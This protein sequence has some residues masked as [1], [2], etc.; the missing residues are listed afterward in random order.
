MLL[1]SV[2]FLAAYSVGIVRYRLML[3]DQVL[4][5]GVLYY[6]VSA[7]VTLVFSL[8][9]AAVA[10]MT[11]RQDLAITGQPILVF[12]ILTLSVV[13]LVWFRDRVQRGIDR[14]FFREKYRL[15]RTLRRV[16]QA[17]SGMLDRRSLADRMLAS[18]A[19]VLST[20]QG[21]IYLR[22]GQTRHFQ[23]ISSFGNGR[24]PGSFEADREFFESLR[25]GVSLQRIRSGS[26]QVQLGMRALE[27]ELVYGLDVDGT[28]AGMIAL[29]AKPNGAAYN[30]EDAAFLAAIGRL[31]GV[32]LHFGRVHE[33]LNRMNTEFVRLNEELG[34]TREQRKRIEDRL[35][36][37]DVNLREA[38]KRIDSYE[39]QLT[40][41]RKETPPQSVSEFESELILGRSPAILSVMETARKVSPTNSSV[42]IR[43]ESGTGKELLARAIHQNSNR[44]A[45][46]MIV[47]HC[48]AL[49][50]GVLESELFGHVKGAFTDAREDK[51]GRFLSANGGTLF[52]DEIGDVPLETQVKLLRALQERMIEPVGSSKSIP[53]DVRVVAATHRNLEQFI[54]EGRFREDLYYRL[55]V[56]SITLPPLREREEDVI[57]LSVQFLRRAAQKAGKVV[58]HFESDVLEWLQE[59]HWPGNVREL[60]N[61]IERAVVLADSEG[62]RLDDLPPALLEPAG[63]A[64]RNTPPKPSRTTSGVPPAVA[65]S[66]RSADRPPASDTRPPQPAD[67]GIAAGQGHQ[68]PSDT[69][70]AVRLAR[71]NATTVV[72]SDEE[73]Q[74][75]QAALA[76]AK[77][78]K[79]RAARLLGLPRSTYFSRMKKHGL[80]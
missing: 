23:M 33:E 37:S 6:V 20:Q 68:R 62:V 60:E 47:V 29:G 66:G 65:G 57:E 58:T 26:S 3:I 28:L 79:A 8:L 77:G 75:L 70:L 53:I 67:P 18:C 32:T 10:Q 9:L 16:N 27:S 74:L 35:L 24:F 40:A 7:A 19:D 44:R 2:L 21:A 12:A 1:A 14:E 72:G 59:Y 80:D 25:S 11:L 76:E 38:L 48:A 34:E 22:E 42:L 45:G 17:V 49:A 43:G 55:N 50:P 56:I 69:S 5:R 36:E 52:L 30:A 41:Q 13:F 73:R 64:R 39:K 61:V 15:N 54:S 71:V 51:P 31:A 46:P 63:R 4:T 78:N